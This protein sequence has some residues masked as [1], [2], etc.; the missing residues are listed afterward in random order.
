M[1]L[2][3]V[4]SDGNSDSPSSTK[5]ALKIS[6]RDQSKAGPGARAKANARKHFKAKGSGSTII[7]GANGFVPQNSYC[8]YYENAP[9]SCNR[10]PRVAFSDGPFQPKDD[11][12]LKLDHLLS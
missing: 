1:D 5:I 6:G 8:R 11:W 2:I 10:N 7:S 3:F 9:L 4:K 12:P